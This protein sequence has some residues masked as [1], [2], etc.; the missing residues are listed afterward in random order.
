[1][2]VFAYQILRERTRGLL[3]IS[4]VEAAREEF[5]SPKM[6]RDQVANRTGFSFKLPSC[7]LPDCLTAT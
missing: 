4:V 5:H 3:A 6:S 7:M 2:M 1:M